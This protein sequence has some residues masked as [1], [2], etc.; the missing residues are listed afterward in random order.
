MVLPEAGLGKGRRHD[1]YDLEVLR[2][3]KIQAHMYLPRRN[4][5]RVPRHEVKHRVVDLDLSAAADAVKGFL[6]RFMRMRIAGKA[7]RIGAGTQPHV[8]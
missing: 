2:S 4:E 1:G 3:V 5:H 6:L 8:L 7:G